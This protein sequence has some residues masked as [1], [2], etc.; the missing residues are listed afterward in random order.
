MLHF[1]IL[2]FEI[3]VRVA[4]CED[5]EE[6]PGDEGEPVEIEDVEHG[7]EDE[8]GVADD[9]VKERVLESVVNLVSL[10]YADEAMALEV[11]AA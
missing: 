3:L 9:L 7:V 8:R 10:D 2:V 11:D 4:A 5:L 1:K 6:A